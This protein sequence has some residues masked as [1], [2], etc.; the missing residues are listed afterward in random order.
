MGV[1]GE[2]GVLCCVDATC[3][4]EGSSNM[5]A[6]VQHTIIV[7]RWNRGYDHTGRNPYVEEGQES[8]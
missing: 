2:L 1:G 6:V 8:L 5:T 3:D 4:G 7:R